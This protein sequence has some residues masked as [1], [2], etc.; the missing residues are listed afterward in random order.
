MISKLLLNS[1]CFHAHDIFLTSQ[2]KDTTP[3]RPL[4]LYL[5][6]DIKQ[7]PRGCSWLQNSLTVIM[8][9]WRDCASNKLRGLCS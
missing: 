8:V 1:D 3:F 9:P 2:V 7:I 5:S 4:Y 6:G